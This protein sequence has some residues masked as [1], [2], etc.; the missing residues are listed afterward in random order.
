MIPLKSATS[1]HPW[2]ETLSIKVFAGVSWAIHSFVDIL[3]PNA[4]N[5]FCDISDKKILI[6]LAIQ[7]SC[8]ACITQIMRNQSILHHSM[9]NPEDDLFLHW[10]YSNITARSM[11]ARICRSAF[12]D[13]DLLYAC[14]RNAELHMLIELSNLFNN[15]AIISHLSKPYIFQT[16]NIYIKTIGLESNS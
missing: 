2:I 4:I 15:Q 10:S 1:E 8:P 3:L 7:Y 13:R 11:S 14:R 12:T 16:Q 6:S 9:I 5:S